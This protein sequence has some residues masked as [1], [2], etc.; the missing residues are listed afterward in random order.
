MYLR[1]TKQVKRERGRRQHL[2]LTQLVLQLLAG[3]GRDGDAS[4][5]RG[6]G[7]ERPWL[8]DEQ[9][10]V[11]RV[12]DRRGHPLGKRYAVVEAGQAR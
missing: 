7:D 5:P 10:L 1:R 9:Q 11:S 8:H 3:L 6:R 12:D 4:R 2:R